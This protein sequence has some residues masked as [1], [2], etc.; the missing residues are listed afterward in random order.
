MADNI[1]IIGQVL[2]TS[3]VNRY[4][5]QD[6][7]LLLPIVQQETFGKPEDYVEYFVFD[8]GG[9][10]LN[11]NYNYNSYKLPSN[12]GYSQSYLPTLEIDPIQD[13]ENLG[14]ES[15]E[16]TSR[17]NFFRKVSGEPFSS[18]LFISQISSDRTELRVGS[19]ELDD[20]ALIDVAS[21]FADKQL[22]V[23]YYYYVILNFGN[24]NQ[25]V[26][27]NVLS[28]VNALGEASLL[29]KLYEALPSNITLKDKFW[30]VE[31]IVNPYI[32][33]LSLSKVITP[34]P[35]PYLKGPNFNIDLEFKDV[36]PTQY[37]NLNQL[38]NPS[39]GPSYPVTP[40][41]SVTPSVT[42]T[43]SV[44]VTPSVTP[45]ITVSVTPSVTITP[46]VTP[47]I[48]VSVTPSASPGNSVSATPSITPSI[49]ISSTPSVTPSI[50][51]SATPSVTPTISI[52]AT[53]SVTPSISISST[54]SITPTITVSVTPSIT[55]S[56]SEPP[57]ILLKEFLISNLSDESNACSLP[58][59][60]T[61]YVTNTT[62]DGG[63]T[64]ATTT[65]EIYTNPAGTITFT[66]DGDYYALFCD[67]LTNTLTT[68]QR[69]TPVGTINGSVGVCL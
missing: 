20:I 63:N 19:T 48:S 12:Y 34:L 39:A 32:Y 49:S 2:D 43:P 52:S 25:V 38:I 37:S 6:E 17:Y 62:I 13:I 16:V 55:P 40:S 15:G 4:D 54:P 45:S 67:D 31:E 57:A 46:S 42:I 26:A 69:I 66:G 35:Q 29:F 65:S 27:V 30:I 58:I 9:N 11:S 64:T 61:V 53:P 36:V 50:T 1:K 18:Q 8:L 5:L 41:I 28:E 59:S 60:N 68:N 56:S 44:T 14:Y 21:N 51:I 22:A 47:T 24:N 3:R 10:V 33:D 23:P 7:Q